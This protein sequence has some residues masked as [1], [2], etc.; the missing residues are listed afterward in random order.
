MGLSIFPFVLRP[1]PGD[2]GVTRGDGI[3]TPL[4]VLPWTLAMLEGD[5]R[6]IKKK[7]GEHITKRV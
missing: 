5:R 3:A 1:L 6:A 2:V 4:Y 7:S